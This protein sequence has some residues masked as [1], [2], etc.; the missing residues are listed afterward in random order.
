MSTE[1][2]LLIAPQF[3]FVEL[4]CVILVL[5]APNDARLGAPVQPVFTGGWVTLIVTVRVTV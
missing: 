5:D 2:T 4:P 1:S 3:S